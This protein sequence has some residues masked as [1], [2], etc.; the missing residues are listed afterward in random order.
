MR[1]GRFTDEQIIAILKQSEAGV[2]T[3]ELCRQHGVN[4]STFYAWRRKFGGME[5]ADAQRLKRLEDEN[6]QLK[7][8]VAD[9][10]LDKKTLEFM[11]S[12]KP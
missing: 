4:P 12:K 11:L 9:L 3:K 7:A 8:L 2:S 10:S 1:K 6:R 5:I